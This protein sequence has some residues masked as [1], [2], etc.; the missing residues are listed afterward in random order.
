MK[1]RLV[2]SSLAQQEITDAL[3]YYVNINPVLAERFLNIIES[4]YISL[5]ENPQHYSFFGDSTILRSLAF[6]AFPYILIFRIVENNV[7]VVALHNTQQ[8]PENFL[9]RS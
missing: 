2:I 1:H 7:W 6:E 4:A 9:N 3:L 8:N 5:E